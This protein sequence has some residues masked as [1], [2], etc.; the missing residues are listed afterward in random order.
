MHEKEQFPTLIDNTIRSDFLKC[1]QYMQRA[2]LQHWGSSRPSVHLHAGG[3]FASSLEAARR[4]FY[5]NDCNEAE[6]L[7]LGLEALIKF[8]G[9]VQFEPT[10]NG[11][12]SLDNVIRAYDSY[13]QRYPLPSDPIK[14]L[15][16]ANGKSMIEFT[17]RGGFAE[18]E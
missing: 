16:L 17:F 3:A 6:S 1:P 4:A 14:P 15:K 13:F 11:D 9:P 2:Y 12:K 10:K 18:Y 5:D 7:R 8:Y